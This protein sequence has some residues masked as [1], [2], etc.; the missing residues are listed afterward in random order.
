MVMTRSKKQRDITRSW[1]ID[2]SSKRE[3]RGTSLLASGI[4]QTHWK[5]QTPFKENRPYTWI[6]QV[7][8]KSRRS[9][10]RPHSDLL[11][12]LLISFCPL[13]LMGRED[14]LTPKANL[15]IRDTPAKPRTS[16]VLRNHAGA[17]FMSTCSWNAVWR[18]TESHALDLTWR[19]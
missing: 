2:N 4:I 15:K 6:V 12:L 11:N 14:H 18:G 3:L 19:Q 16:C 1:K 13:I 7:C 17:D 5:E 8:N 9:Y 10:L